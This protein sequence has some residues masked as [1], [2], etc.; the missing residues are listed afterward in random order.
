MIGEGVH[1]TEGLSFQSSHHLGL[2]RSQLLIQGHVFPI[3]NVY[4]VQVE[5]SH[6]PKDVG[7]RGF[8]LT[9]VG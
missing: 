7:R 9:S 3:A 6:L 4:N 8:L 5:T 1:C 2:S